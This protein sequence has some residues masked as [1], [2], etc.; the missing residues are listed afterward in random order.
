M[1]EQDLALL[2]K[3]IAAGYQRQ[4]EAERF[5]GMS[6]KT[7]HLKALRQAADEMINP[8]VMDSKKS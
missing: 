5:N 8:G 6:P 3:M 1:P 7:L 4:I 2:V